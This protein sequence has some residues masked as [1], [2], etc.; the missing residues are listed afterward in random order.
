MKFNKEQL[1]NLLPHRDPMLLIN[2]VE[3]IQNGEDILSIAH[4][5]VRG[6]E[7]FLQGHFPN[8]PV[9]P[10]VILCEMMTQAC[11][12]FFIGKETNVD[13]YLTTLDSVKFKNPVRPGDTIQLRAKFIKTNRI[14]TFASAEALVRDKLVARCELSFALVPKA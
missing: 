2:D 12:V 10:G 8:N 4:Y 7:F 6:D 13:T 9:V 11:C 3:L 5:T 14:F 1:H